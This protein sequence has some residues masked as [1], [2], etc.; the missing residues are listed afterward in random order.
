MTV[1]KPPCARHTSS[2]NDPHSY[3]RTSNVARERERERARQSLHF[4]GFRCAAA[5][6]QGPGLATRKRQQATRSKTSPS[7]RH[8]SM[9]S[10]T[11]RRT[12]TA[13]NMS[14]ALSQ[15]SMILF[16]CGLSHGLILQSR[17]QE[18][19]VSTLKPWALLCQYSQLGSFLAQM[20]EV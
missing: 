7:L 2:K 5:S 9:A 14:I 4:R 3:K 16:G 18:N 12:L 20:K 6:H 11:M 8:L 15:V 13:I 19:R 17:D 1:S 10:M